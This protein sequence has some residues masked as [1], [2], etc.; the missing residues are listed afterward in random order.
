MSAIK[1]YYFCGVKI[2]RTQ[3]INAVFGKEMPMFS[4]P[5]KITNDPETFRKFHPSRNLEDRKL[6]SLGFDMFPVMEDI[7]IGVCLK[8]FPPGVTI[9]PIGKSVDSAS[10]VL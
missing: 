3:F 5:I 4:I 6:L 2:S 7:F 8:F 1:H 10:S 9:C